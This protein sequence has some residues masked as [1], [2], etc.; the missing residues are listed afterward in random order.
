M[1][2]SLK[3]A[4][5][6]AKKLASDANPKIQKEKRPGVFQYNRGITGRR[7]FPY[8]GQKKKTRAVKYLGKKDTH[9]GS[10]F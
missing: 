4:L 7:T 5:R 2:E 6:K 1:N 8:A 3:E 9:T 10:N